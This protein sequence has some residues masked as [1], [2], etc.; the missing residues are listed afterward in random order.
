MLK[1]RHKTP[2]WKEEKNGGGGR[3]RKLLR[4]KSFKIVF[5]RILKQLGTSK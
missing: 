3:G 4:K 5:M 2:V 1:R